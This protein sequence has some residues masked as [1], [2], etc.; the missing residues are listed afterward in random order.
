[1]ASPSSSEHPINSPNW[2]EAYPSPR[3]RTKQPL[4]QLSPQEVGSMLQMDLNYSYSRKALLIVD[5]RRA[6]CEV[7]ERRELSKEMYAWV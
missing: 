5:V 4:R 6:D 2:H 3:D 1:M 7:R